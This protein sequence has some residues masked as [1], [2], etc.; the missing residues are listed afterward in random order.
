MLIFVY[1]LT[2]FGL[3]TRTKNATLYGDMAGGFAVLADVWKTWV[4]QLAEFIN[5]EQPSTG[6]AFILG[7]VFVKNEDTTNPVQ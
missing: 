2:F 1:D 6:K 7:Y 3:F 5:I 4:Y